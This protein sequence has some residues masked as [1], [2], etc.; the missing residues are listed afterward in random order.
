MTSVAIRFPV[1]AEAPRHRRAPVWA[2]ALLSA[3]AIASEIDYDVIGIRRLPIVVLVLMA[4]IVLVAL[5]SSILP[6]VLWTRPV[7]G[8]TIAVAW[9]LLTVA[10]SVVPVSTARAMLSIIGLFVVAVWYVSEFGFPRFAH[11]YVATMAGFLT[12][13]FIRDLIIVLGSDSIHRFDGYGVHATDL[14]RLALVTVM[15]ATVQIV[16]RISR[17]WVMWWGLA[18]GM[19][20]LVAT[21][22]R[23]TL[24]ALVLC[25]F[26]V[27]WRTLGFGRT[28][29]I[30][31]TMAAGLA[32]AFS[33]VPDP[34]K[35]VARDE[36]GR[37]ITSVSG[38]LTIWSVAL[39]LTR[40]SPVVGHGVASGELLF[41]QASAAGDLPVL[42]IGHAHNML[43]EIT[44]TQGLIG[45]ALTGIAL[46]GY[47]TARASPGGRL[48]SVILIA[49]LLSGVTEAILGRPS[50][51]YLVIGALLAE[52]AGAVNSTRRR[53]G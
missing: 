46:G 31:I 21:G 11:V 18:I 6:H 32:L 45:L 37:D 28:L 51:L 19:V 20:A 36:R 9:G 41:P 29:L 49:I 13:G 53:P 23:T 12:A 14:A 44:V 5:R 47:F 15:I 39:D 16:E 30:G 22:T 48:S 17:H 26:I 34:S 25:L 10:W 42:I 4:P 8:F 35:F 50:A 40:D 3:Q 1:A 38:R 27:S 24:I 33:S 2:G 52:R 43:L 7:R